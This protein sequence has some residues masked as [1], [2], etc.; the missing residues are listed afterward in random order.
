MKI[1]LYEEDLLL[2]QTIRLFEES[3]LQLFSEGL[4]NGTTHTAV[5]QEDIPF[6]I[7][8][9]IN[10][11]NDK[12]FSNHRCHAHYLTLTQDYQGLLSEI[13]GKKG[14][15]CG[16]LGGSQ[17]LCNGYFFSSGIQASAF[18]IAAGCAEGIKLNKKKGK[19]VLYMGEGTFGQGLVYEVFNYV[20]LKQLPIIFIVEDNGI[21]QSTP[22]RMNTSGTIEGRAKAFN[23][24][25]LYVGYGNIFE[26]IELVNNYMVSWEKSNQPAVI[27]FKTNRLN[28]HSKG[29]DTRENTLIDEIKKKDFMIELKKYFGRTKFDENLKVAKYF[30]EQLIIEMKSLPFEQT[31]Y[32]LDEL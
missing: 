6:I 27:H 12:I 18:P 19:V 11:D 13:M 15:V 4:L 28:A 14:G 1:K 22:F 9:H 7:S 5:G 2:L 29:D 24:D 26:R 32:F 23:L 3:L 25:Y 8:K 17:H 20:S 16:G 31:I 30:I 21:S 10:K